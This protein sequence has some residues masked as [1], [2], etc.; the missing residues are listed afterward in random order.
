MKPLYKAWLIHIEVTNACIHRCS[1]CTR[2][3]NH[4]AK[5]YFA[6]LEFIEKGLRSL[7][8]WRGG[9]GCMGGEPTI[10]P[11][12]AEICELYQL[13]V[14]RDRAGLWTSGGPRYEKHKELIDRTFG[15]KLYNDHSEVGRHQPLLVASEEVVPDETLRNELIDKCWIQE[16]WSPSI[17]PKGAFFCEVAAMLDLLFDGPGGY[18]IEPGWWKRDVADF[19]DQRDRYCRMCSMA[20]PMR[21]LPNNLPF[22]FVSPGNAER[23]KQAGSP[24][25][26]KG[27]L[28]IFR[29][30]YTREITEKVRRLY[31]PMPW[32]YLGANE[33]RDGKK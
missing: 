12:F 14:P 24:L 8:D 15:I 4:I 18:P 7:S 6:D 22:D 2:A 31:N 9:I 5:P 33:V 16:Q 28:K 3:C 29:Q 13:H 30:Q 32:E 17:N 19:R 11:R 26:L 27:R 25:A 1:H 23:L 20:L 10:H 21:N